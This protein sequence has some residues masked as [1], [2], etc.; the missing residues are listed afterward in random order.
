MLNTARNS[1]SAWSMSTHRDIHARLK[2]QRETEGR[3]MRNSRKTGGRWRLA[4]VALVLGMIGACHATCPS[5]TVMEGGLCHKSQQSDLLSGSGSGD[6]SNVGAAGY[7]SSPARQAS[8]ASSSTAGFGSPPSSQAAGGSSSGVNQ[9][10]RNAAGTSGVGSNAGGVGESLAAGNGAAMTDGSACGPEICDNKDND[11]DQRIDEDVTRPCGPQMIGVC[12]PGTEQC[13]A[14]T[15]TGM[16]LNAVNPGMEVCDAEGQDENC[17]GTVNEMCAC[18]PAAT[19]PCGSKVGVCKQGTQTCTAAGQW[20]TECT[21]GVSPGTEVCD[22][23]MDENCNGMVDEGCECTNGKTMDCG[24]DVG[25]CAKGKKTC[26]DGK[27]GTTCE[28]ERAPA[29]ETCDGVDNDCDGKTDE[30]LLNACGGCSS[31]RNPPM[32]SCSAGQNS[33]ATTGQYICLGQ[34]A[35]VCDAP[36]NTGTPEQCDGVDNDCDGKTD[37]DLENAC[38]GSCLNKLPHQVGD[39]CTVQGTG[40]CYVPGTWQC[41]GTTGMRCASKGCQYTCVDGSDTETTTDPCGWAAN[42]MRSPNHACVPVDTSCS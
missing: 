17:D 30:G 6:L 35:T 12:R 39:T 13:V 7:E 38:G 18:T 33:C 15:W 21:G 11:C 36:V 23:A 42:P 31:L 19:Q 40:N 3:Y 22:G 9:M 5:G 4:P 16:C 20:P 34:D 10:A 37:E 26:K 25:A 29:T 28:G 24:M 32:S 8:G 41:S 2:E 1:Y 27:W 14:G